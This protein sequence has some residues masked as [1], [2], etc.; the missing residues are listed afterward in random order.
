MKIKV[1][2]INEINKLISELDVD[3]KHEK[4]SVEKKRL[5]EDQ[6]SLK[7]VLKLIP[8]KRVDISLT[9]VAR[10]TSPLDTWGNMSGDS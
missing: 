1:I 6:A 7:R 10:P 3:I 9:P 4:N 8:A 5:V 2:F